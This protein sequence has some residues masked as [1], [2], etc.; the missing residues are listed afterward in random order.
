MTRR[1]GCARARQPKKL[2]Q[3]LGQAP[4]FHEVRQWGTPPLTPRAPSTLPLSIL[5]VG[6]R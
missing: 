3:W 1:K 5:Q 2:R 4:V 6:A